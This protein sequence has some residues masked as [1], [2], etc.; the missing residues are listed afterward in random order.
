M[1]YLSSDLSYHISE[2]HAFKPVK[3]EKSRSSECE[4]LVEEHL[5]FLTPARKGGPAYGKQ[6]LQGHDIPDAMKAVTGN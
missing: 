3:N 2:I 4:C 5:Y 1:A 6:K